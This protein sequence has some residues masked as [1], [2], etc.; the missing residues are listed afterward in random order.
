MNEFLST[1]ADTLAATL[2]QLCQNVVRH[3]A[4][5]DPG[6][7]DREPP[8]IREGFSVFLK[9]VAELAQPRPKF[10]LGRNFDEERADKLLG[11]AEHPRVEVKDR[12][13]TFGE[14]VARKIDE[15]CF[16]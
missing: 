7:N 16:S 15:G 3:A 12:H 5:F 2:K 13:A 9:V 4:S 6:P 14:A 10:Q 1:V 11:A 8:E